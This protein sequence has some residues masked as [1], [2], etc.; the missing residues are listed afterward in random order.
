[1][2]ATDYQGSSTPLNII[3]HSLLSM[4][5]DQVHAMESPNDGSASH[6]FEL[7]SFQRQVADRFHNLA[8]V[9]PDELLSLPWVRKLLD[10]FLCCQEEFRLILFNNKAQVIKPPMDRLIAEYYERTVKALDVCNAIRDGIEQIKQWQKLLEIVLCAL[11]DNNGIPNNNCCQRALGEGQFRRAKKALI[12]LAIGMLDEKDSGQALSHRNRSFG[13][14]NNS[15]SHSKDHHH[16]PLGHFRSLSWS[17]SR[18]WSAA[19]Q[20]LAIGN[21]LA[22]PRGSDVVATNGLVIPVYTMGC[23]LLFVMW[24][25]VA[26]IPC[27]DRG[28]EVHFYVPRHFSWAAPLLSLHERIL[29]ESKKRDRKNACALLREIY[30][31]EKCTRLLGELTDTVQFPLCEEKEMEVR[32]RVKELGQ[33]FDAMKE[34]LEPLEKQVREVFHRIVRSRTEGL[35]SLG[36][37]NNTE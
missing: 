4:K 13:R 6:D 34:G 36:R 19:R 21:N 5:R 25:L 3:G 11:G 27:Q 22:V 32:Q 2:P 10:V 29:E 33:V 8:S 26:A 7:G 15:T 24:A 12:D 23:V 1:M 16:R 31:M 14:N 17:V 37:G 18:S 35:G 28:L 20:L 9:P 30:Q